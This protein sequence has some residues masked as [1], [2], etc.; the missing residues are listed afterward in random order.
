M[1]VALFVPCYIDQL[2]PQVAIA[3]LE[4]LQKLGVQVEVPRDQT[5]CGQPM[6][7][8][9]CESASRATMRHF[10][11]TFARYDYVVGPTGSCVY[12]VRQHYDILDQ[13]EAV[14]QVRTRIYDLVQFL[15]EVVDL[16]DRFENAFPYRVGL[17]LSCHGLR[18]M[19]MAQS[20]E[21]VAPPF[22]MIG[23]LLARVPGLELVELNRRDE[24]CGFGGT[25]AVTQAAVSTRMGQ[26]RLDDHQGQGAEVLTGGDMSCLMHL[27]GLIRREKRPLRVL[28]IAQILNAAK[29]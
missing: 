19:R 29:D 12:H 4:L 14:T 20:S 17:H 16:P 8:T 9:G 10:V 2:Y 18:G 7:N 25:F 27:E 21:R 23:D 3:T 26:D 5:C 24:C 13:T 15:S 22:S 6:A 1:R 28:H 11:E